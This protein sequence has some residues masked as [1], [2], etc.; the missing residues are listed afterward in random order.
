MRVR[1]LIWPRERAAVGFDG[2]LAQPASQLGS[3]QARTGSAAWVMLD[4]IA[5]VG[6]AGSLSTDVDTAASLCVHSY[7]PKSSG[8]GSSTDTL[9]L[10]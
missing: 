1:I 9:G 5:V 6:S 4:Y 3:G 10:P 2:W 8:N 7:I